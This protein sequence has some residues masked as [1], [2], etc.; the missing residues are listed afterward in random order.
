ME[1]SDKNEEI[2]ALKKALRQE[3]RKNK[4]LKEKYDDIKLQYRILQCSD[5]KKARELLLSSLSEKERQLV[6]ILFPDTDTTK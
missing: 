1:K 2:K 5:K 6:E 3:Q 4:V